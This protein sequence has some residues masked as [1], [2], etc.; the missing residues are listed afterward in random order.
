MRQFG[1]V[2]STA[3]VLAFAAPA[4]APTPGLFPGWEL[5]SAALAASTSVAVRTFGIDGMSC[6]D[7]MASS[8][9]MRD[10]RAF[11]L[12]YWAATN[13]ANARNAR[14]GARSNTE[15]I[16]V[17]VYK[18]CQARGGMSLPEATEQTYRRFEREGR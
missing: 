13:R 11:I 3:L 4:G 1:S 8:V 6:A 12:G 7:W 15:D 10:G 14:V 17:A 5:S 2:V 16:L 9:Q 18:A